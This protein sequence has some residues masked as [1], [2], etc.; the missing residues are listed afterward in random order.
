MRVLFGIQD[1]LDL[2]NDDYVL[3]ALDAMEAQRKAQIEIRKKDKKK[4]AVLHP[5]VCG[6]KHI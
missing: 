3:V 6:C 1:V 5:L 4:G 2:V